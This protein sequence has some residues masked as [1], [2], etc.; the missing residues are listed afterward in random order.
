MH[1]V[2]GGRSGGL[3]G[4]HRSLSPASSPS[5]PP[6]PS[7]VPLTF[8][9][10]RY[11]LRRPFRSSLATI[12]YFALPSCPHPPLVSSPHVLSCPLSFRRTSSFSPFYFPL[13][14][15]LSLSFSLFASCDRTTQPNNRHRRLKP[16][17][18][19]AS[20]LLSFVPLAARLFQ[21]LRGDFVV[22]SFPTRILLSTI[23]TKSSCVSV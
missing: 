11:S 2:A 5:T 17:N 3:G 20:S 14:L 4:E 12:L 1:D 15:S 8:C 23:G 7:T 9:S 19:A 22:L 21:F 18:S 16:E 6:D 13:S 10:L